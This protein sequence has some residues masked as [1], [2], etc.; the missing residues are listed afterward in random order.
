MLPSMVA[1]PIS[2]AENSWTWTTVCDCWGVREVEED[3]EGINGNE[4]RLDLGW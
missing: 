1:A 2:K 4:R 3:T